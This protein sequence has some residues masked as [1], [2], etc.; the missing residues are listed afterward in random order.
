M[1]LT[2][3]HETHSSQVKGSK[4]QCVLDQVQV[5]TVQEH[6]FRWP[7]MPCTKFGEVFTVAEQSHKSS[8]FVFISF[9]AWG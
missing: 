1:L 9:L 2:G 6:G 5:T 7:Q 8:T 3:V 4:R